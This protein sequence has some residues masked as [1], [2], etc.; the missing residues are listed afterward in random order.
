MNTNTGYYLVANLLDIFL[1]ISCFDFGCAHRLVHI[2]A[3]R[4]FA[5][6]YCTL[7][8]FLIGFAVVTVRMVSNPAKCKT[9]LPSESIEE[10]HRALAEGLDL[11]VVCGT[12]ATH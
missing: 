11:P 1:I 7:M 5:S 2:H 4:G 12:V 9:V 6:L 8:S 3:Y 10:H